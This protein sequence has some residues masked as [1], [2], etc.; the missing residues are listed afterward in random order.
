MNP[1]SII[2]RKPDK[3]KEDR[4]GSSGATLP[5]RLSGTSPETLSEYQQNPVDAG[6]GNDNPNG[7]TGNDWPYPDY[8][9]GEFHLGTGNGDRL[10]DMTSRHLHEGPTPGRIPH[11]WND[12]KAGKL[13]RDVT[14]NPTG[15]TGFA[16]TLSGESGQS[17][18]IGDMVYIP[19]TPTPR[20]T[21]VARPYLRTVDDSASIPGVYVAD[22][23]RR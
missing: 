6:L 20:N 3:Q 8:P 23:T 2:N 14:G 1:L 16:N 18:G 12:R 11:G 10:Q 7:R 5:I 21:T 22:A 9:R 17:G 13:G 4:S 19:H 15:D